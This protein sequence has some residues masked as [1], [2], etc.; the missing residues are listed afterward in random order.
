MATMVKIKVEVNEPAIQRRLND[1]CHDEQT[2][3]EIHNLL[4]KMCDPYVP[5]LNGPLS[6]SGMANVTSSGVTYTTPYARRQ[7]YGIGF[8][9]TIEVHPLASAMWDKAMLRDKGDLFNETVKRILIRRANEL[10]G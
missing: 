6:L 5:Y 3:L 2:M 1:L 9:H 4:A 7:Y 8:N 10:Y